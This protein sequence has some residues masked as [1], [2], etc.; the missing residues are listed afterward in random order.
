M[1]YKR[2]WLW[3]L[4]VSLGV[5]VL[6]L[7]PWRMCVVIG[8]SMEPFL[9]S[10]DVVILNRLAQNEIHRGSLVVFRR[11]GQV[12]IKKVHAIPGDRVTEAYFLDGSTF[13]VVP[14]GE[15]KRWERLERTFLH[16]RNRLVKL[17]HLQIPPGYFYVLGTG[18]SSRDSR[19]FGLVPASSLV[20]VVTYGPH[21][22]VPPADVGPE[23][24]SVPPRIQGRCLCSG[25]PLIEEHKRTWGRP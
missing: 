1:R 7:L 23:T 14:P 22:E 18:P 4:L 21:R 6:L 15:E 20:G 25:L 9:R 13:C 10:G 16:G 19:D 3:G 8:S 24:L 12:S 11:D 5:F 17:L 2:P